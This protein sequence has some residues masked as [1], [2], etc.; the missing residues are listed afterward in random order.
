MRHVD[1]GI[2]HPKLAHLYTDEHEKLAYLRYNLESRAGLRTPTN[3]WIAFAVFST[4]V[5]EECPRESCEVR[6]ST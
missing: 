3:S 5:E 6:L 2:P 1:N 4:G